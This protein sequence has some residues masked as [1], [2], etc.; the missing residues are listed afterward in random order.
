MIVA[1]TSTKGGT[2]KTTTVCNLAATLGRAGYDVLAVDLDPQASLTRWY[3]AVEGP[4]LADVL[5]GESALTGAVYTDERFGF[6]LVPASRGLRAVEDE[7][8]R[9]ERPLRRLVHE[10][11]D[12]CLI[13]TPP[14]VSSF[15]SAGVEVSAGVVIP[16]EASMAAMDT[17][18]DSLEVVRQLG[19]HVLGVLVCRVDPRTSND[20]SV[21][22]HLKE[23]YGDLIFET[24]IRESVAVR[25]S[26]AE[27]VPTVAAYADVNAAKDYKD[28]S[29][30]L[31]ARI[32][33][34]Q[35]KTV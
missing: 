16:I 5:G 22:P 29:L 17:L 35:K 3:G 32:D 19:G 28:F 12:M 7:L 11:Y 34:A 23:Q 21:H 30:E 10:H 6:D 2:G 26:H 33:H 24:Q 4:T 18:N 27:R 13:D 14:S 8:G 25:D 31:K 20:I 9:L 1:I 15:T